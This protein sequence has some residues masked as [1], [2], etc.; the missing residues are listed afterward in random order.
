MAETAK[1]GLNALKCIQMYISQK[2]Q[3]NTK[4]M[5]TNAKNGWKLQINIKFQSY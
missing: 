2:G 4:K 5:V 1:N 3:Q